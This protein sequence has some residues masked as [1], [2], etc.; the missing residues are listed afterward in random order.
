M[1][2]AAYEMRRTKGVK[3]AIPYFR[4]AQKY[5]N[6]DCN[7]GDNV[8]CNKLKALV[9]TETKNHISVPE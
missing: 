5:L 2:Y 8:A 7:S 4:K 9:E 6:L 1:N 3:T